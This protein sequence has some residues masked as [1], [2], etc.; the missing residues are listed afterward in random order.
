LD[1]GEVFNGLLPPNVAKYYEDGGHGNSSAYESGHPAAEKPCLECHLNHGSTTYKLLPGAVQTTD[2]ASRSGADLYDS[3]GRVVKGYDYADNAEV[4]STSTH[5]TIGGIPNSTYIDYTDFTVVDRGSTTGQTSSDSKARM[6]VKYANYTTSGAWN[7]YYEATDNSGSATSMNPSGTQISF[8]TSGDRVDQNSSVPCGAELTGSA[9]SYEVGF[10]DVCHIYNDANDGT[11]TTFNGMRTHAGFVTP[12]DCGGEPNYP[13]VSANFQKDCTECH[14]PHG[15]GD[16]G[17]SNPNWYM[18]RGKIVTSDDGSNIETYNLVLD[19]PGSDGVFV[20]Q[21]SLDEDDTDNKDDM[22]AVCHTTTDHNRRDGTAQGTHREDSACITCHLHIDRFMPSGGCV[23]CHPV[24][25]DTMH[26]KHLNFIAGALAGTPGENGIFD[27]DNFLAI[28]YCAVCHGD[29]AGSGANH[30]TGYGAQPWPPGY[31]S[32]IVIDHRSDPASSWGDNPTYEGRSL[33]T[34]PMGGGRCGDVD[35]HGNDDDVEDAFLPPYNRE[36]GQL[37]LKW[38]LHSIEP[39][40]EGTVTPN[41]EPELSRVCQSCHDAYPADIRIF[42]ADGTTLA[43]GKRGSGADC[44]YLS[45]SV[46]SAANYY[47]AVAYVPITATLGTS[48]GRG[49]HGDDRLSTDGLDVDSATAITP[50]DCSA[51]HFGTGPTDPSHVPLSATNMN[52][53]RVN[54][55][56][57]DS[58]HTNAGL[59]NNDGCHVGASYPGIPSDRRH[60]PSYVNYTWSN[61]V[62][63]DVTGLTTWDDMGGGYF[64]QSDYGAGSFVGSGANYHAFSG[65]PD[66]FIDWYDRDTG[67]LPSDKQSNDLS[68]LTRGV[69]LFENGANVLGGPPRATLPLERYIFNAGVSTKVLCVTCHNPHGT[70]LYIHDPAG[71]GEDIADH[72]M[73]R[74]QD[75]DSTL[76]NACH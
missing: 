75:D 65:N 70:D 71:I 26:I 45:S 30:T 3:G 56:L 17:T 19:D 28:E 13:D 55:I 22:C 40:T 6:A 63:S 21:D 1:S 57:E 54:V 60:H 27:G 34:T 25:L 29:G 33:P 35:C 42:R 36:G 9:P 8:G 18:I 31:E 14:D 24:H 39:H 20:G 46:D 10:C 48:Y 73:L 32:E 62:A 7:T 58:A 41:D 61:S 44:E 68:P 51:C 72:N 64:M 43:Y 37:P 49:G 76:C 67:W 5:F 47:G 15:S 38:N 16:E 52:G 4:E 74:L 69:F 23:E 11:T 2:H 53:N 66:R 12:N 50:L 59:C